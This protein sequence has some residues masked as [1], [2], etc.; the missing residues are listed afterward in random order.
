LKSLDIGDVRQDNSSVMDLSGLTE[1]ETLKIE[2][3]SVRRE[4]RKQ[5]YD[6]FKEHDL[7]FLSNLK[8]L[9]T[10]SIRGK[11]ITDNAIKN[12]SSLKNLKSISIYTN[13]ELKLTDKSINSLTGSKELFALTI[14]D[15]HFTDKALE[16]LSGM[17][18]L[19]L[20]ELT[21]DF[22][23]SSKAIRSF[24]QKNPNVKNLRL[25]P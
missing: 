16:Y 24:K 14:M 8:N 12:L 6:S 2:L 4:D 9:T 22:A 17:Q 19:Y 21:S 15:G 23:F 3:H 10:I 18:N 1:L 20:L 11:G 5:V 7:A 13:N 25:M